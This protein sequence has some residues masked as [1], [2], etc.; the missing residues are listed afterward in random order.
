MGRERGGIVLLFDDNG[1]F[2]AEGEV[3]TVCAMS[4]VREVLRRGV[5][6]RATT[7]GQGF[8]E[9]GEAIVYGG[10]L[11]DWRDLVVEGGVDGIGGARMIFG[12]RADGQEHEREDRAGWLAVVWLG[13]EA[14]GG[15]LARRQLG[16]TGVRYNVVV[17]VRVINVT[18]ARDDASFCFAWERGYGVWELSWLFSLSNARSRMKILLV[19]SSAVLFGLSSR[20]PD[21]FKLAKRD[22]A[23]TYG[24]SL[25]L[26]S[27][28]LNGSFMCSRL[29]AGAA[30]KAS[31][32]SAVMIRVAS[33][34]A[35]Y[36]KKRR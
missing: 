1:V 18:F 14:E 32:S 13:V 19:A 5:L 15:V 34:W 9:C 17:G 7:D 27:S 21:V 2:R 29:K 12:G 35:S 3:V 11:S 22:K 10:K 36:K 25:G 23:P 26:W 8:A 20:R 16:N 33:S 31:A 4:D 24:E 6:R 30:R 28:G